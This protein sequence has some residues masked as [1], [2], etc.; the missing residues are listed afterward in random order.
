[1][2]INPFKETIC[3]PLNVFISGTF[4]TLSLIQFWLRMPLQHVRVCAGGSKPW[5][6]MTKSQKLWLLRKQSLL[7]LKENCQFRCRNWMRKEL[8]WKRYYNITSPPLVAIKFIFSHF[9]ADIVGHKNQLS[10]WKNDRVLKMWSLD[11]FSFNRSQTSCKLWT[12]SLKPWHKRRKS[13]RQTL[14]SARR[15]WIELRSWLVDLAERRTDG[16]RPLVCLERESPTSPGTSFCRLLLW[17]TLEPSPLT[18]DR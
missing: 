16:Q 8:S 11:F 1:M 12:M 2:I 10:K 17:H 6:S 9:V 15:S 5:T 4:L 3:R 14:I 13:W 7:R 18:S